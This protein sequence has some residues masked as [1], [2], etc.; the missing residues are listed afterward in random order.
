MLTRREI[1]IDGMNNWKA[2]H[3]DRWI[4]ESRNDEELCG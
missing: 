3:I 2:W 4:D 1:E